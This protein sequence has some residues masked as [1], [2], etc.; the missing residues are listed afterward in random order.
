MSKIIDEKGL[1][2]PQQVGVDLTVKYIAQLVGGAMINE[3][4]QH[5]NQLEIFPYE[6]YYDLLP[7]AYSVTFDQGLKALDADEHA[8]VEQRSSLNRN[9]SRLQGSVY[10]PGYFTPNLGATLYVG[11]PIKIAE[12]ARVAQLLIELNEP[13]TLYAGQYQ[14]EAK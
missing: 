9:G 11:V 1:A 2:R 13:A 6:G 4:T 10:D 14:G 8:Y 12:H 5:G 7:G 3:S